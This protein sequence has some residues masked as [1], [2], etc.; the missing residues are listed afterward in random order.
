M[1]LNKT[2]WIAALLLLLPLS[3]SALDEQRL[4]TAIRHAEGDN[5]RWLYGIH[6][7][8]TIALGESEAR[9]RCLET[10]EANK[11]RWQRAAN[12]LPYLEWLSRAYCPLNSQTWLK[13]VRWFYNHPTKG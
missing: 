2:K 1:S 13:N 10:I 7:R 8:S 5:P 9:A 6:H 4:A 3:A 11:A 12:K